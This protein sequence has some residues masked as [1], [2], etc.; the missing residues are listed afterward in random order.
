MAREIITVTVAES[1]SN[2][3][4]VHIDSVGEAYKATLPDRPAT[5]L[6]KTGA[7]SGSVQVILSG[8]VSAPVEAL[9]GAFI[10]LDNNTP[11]ALTTTKP[12]GDFQIIGRMIDNGLMVEPSQ[13]QITTLNAAAVASFLQ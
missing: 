12:A 8:T 13:S 11:G 10:Y 5:G 4:A 3:S 7:A 1:I 6:C 2:N 9:N